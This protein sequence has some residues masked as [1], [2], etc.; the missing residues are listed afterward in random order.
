MNPEAVSN[1][2]AFPHVCL[3]RC[4]L[5]ENVLSVFVVLSEVGVQVPFDMLMC[6]RVC[7]S[8]VGGCWLGC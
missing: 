3:L 5:I 7:G 6:M 1:L 2:F 4:I 8:K